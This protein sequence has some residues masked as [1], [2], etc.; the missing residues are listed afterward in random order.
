MATLT[1]MMISMVFRAIALVFSSYFLFKHYAVY[2]RK[3][4]SDKH[5]NMDKTT[6]T[7]AMWFVT[8]VIWVLLLAHVII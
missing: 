5:E 4:N 3:I 6:L 1:G 8:T 2:R 7:L